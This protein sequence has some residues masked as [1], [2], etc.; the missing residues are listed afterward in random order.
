MQGN[1]FAFSIETIIRPA[2]HQYFSA[3]EKIPPHIASFN[4]R[5]CDVA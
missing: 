3:L 5:A 4:L 2:L 1:D